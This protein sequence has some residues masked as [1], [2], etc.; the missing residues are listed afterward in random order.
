MN[1]SCIWD[2]LSKNDRYL[3]SYAIY[4]TDYE[5]HQQ[6][7]GEMLK[8]KNFSNLVFLEINYVYKILRT[9]HGLYILNEGKEVAQK[10]RITLVIEMLEEHLQ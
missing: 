5:R 7:I 10:H 9:W 6:N 3:I 2:Q 8:T 1:L 4:H